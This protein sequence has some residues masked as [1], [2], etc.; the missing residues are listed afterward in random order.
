MQEEHFCET[1]FGF[2]W[3]AATVERLTSDKGWVVI[4]IKTPR[5]SLQVYVTKTGLVRV[6]DKNSKEWRP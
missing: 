2:E 6:H 4:G 3:Q 1:R 5:Q